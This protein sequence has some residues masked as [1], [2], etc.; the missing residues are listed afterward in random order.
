MRLEELAREYRTTA[1]VFA[2]RVN[3]LRRQLAAGRLG[4]MEQYRLYRRIEMLTGMQREL[5]ATARVLERYYEG[6]DRH[7]RLR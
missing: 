3:T 1:A 7:A 5:R 4:A 2:D 6:A